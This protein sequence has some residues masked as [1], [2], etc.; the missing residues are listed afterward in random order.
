MSKGNIFIISAPS[1]TGKNTLADMLLEKYSYLER[2]I[3][4]TTRAP[5]GKEKNGADYFF[6]SKDEFERKI[7]EGDFLEYA[8]IYQD[9]YGTSKS[10]V[11]NI[12]NKGKDVLLVID[13]QG[14]RKLKKLGAILIFILPP[15]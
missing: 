7:S 1:G 3:T 6:I 11:E 9:Y 2:S 8:N 15:S 10:Q 5:R 4:F 13:V 14:A 12:L